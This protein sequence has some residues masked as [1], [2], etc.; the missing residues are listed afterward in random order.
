MQPCH[1]LIWMPQVTLRTD[2]TVATDTYVCAQCRL[3]VRYSDGAW[4]S[5]EG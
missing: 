1:G 5:L 3:P 2:G 4:I